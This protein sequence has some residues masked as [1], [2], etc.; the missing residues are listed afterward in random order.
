MSR[1]ISLVMLVLLAVTAFSSGITITA[2]APSTTLFPG[3]F[4]AYN[5]TN[6]FY[7]LVPSPNSTGYELKPYMVI[8]A[9]YGI[10]V[11]SVYPNGTALIN[12]TNYVVDTVKYNLTTGKVEVLKNYTYTSFRTLDNAS[13]PGFLYYI[14]PTLLG[15]QSIVRGY[16]VTGIVEYGGLKDGYYVY[17]SNQSFKQAG[18]RLVFVMYVNGTNGLAY[19]VENLQYSLLYNDSLIFNSTYVLWKSNIANPNESP[20]SLTGFTS[21][22]TV[23]VKYLKPFYRNII[24]G[25]VGAGIVASAVILLFWYNREKGK[26]K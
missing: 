6:T 26:R 9:I 8:H 14:S 15:K 25:I 10:R 11:I 24:F 19:K 23:T 20:P 4:A 2:S 7:A 12:F 17:L 5:V 13:A 21:V 22:I 16:N 1:S 3:A 18:V